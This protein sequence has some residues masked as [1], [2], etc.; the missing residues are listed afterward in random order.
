MKNLKGKTILV[1][2]DEPGYRE[3]LKE[4]LALMG[5]H[6][7]EA[8]S[9]QEALDACKNQPQI[10]ALISDVNMPGLTIQTFV[11]QFAKNFPQVPI[12][13]MSGDTSDPKMTEL[14]GI[15]GIFSKPCSMNELFSFLSQHL[16]I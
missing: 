5:A 8:G 4:E 13:L 12:I 15:I 1:V 2:D 6:S 11:N 16:E 3:I 14:L 9:G 7:I 10:H